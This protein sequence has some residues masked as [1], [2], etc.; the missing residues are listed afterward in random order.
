MKRMVSFLTAVVVALALVAVPFTGLAEDV[1]F[2]WF[3]DVS[4]WGPANWN[5]VNSSPLLDT[6]KSELGA[7]FE[8][9]QPATDAATKLALMIATNDLPDL[10][11]ITDS[12]TIA[13]LIESGYV[14]TIPEFVEKYDP[15]SHLLVDFPED[16]K[17][18]IVD[19]YGD[20]WF[21]PSHME[22]VQH[23]ETYPL[24]SQAYINNVVYGQNSSIMFNQKIMDDLGLTQEDV[25]TQSAFMATLQKVKDSGYTVNG[26][27]VIVATMNA[28][29]WLSSLN[30]VMSDSFG[31]V[32]VDAEGNYRRIEMNPGF[33]EVLKFTNDM[34]RGGYM[35]LDILTLDENALV[36][37]IEA[38]QVFC[39]FGN[40]AQADLSVSNMTSFGPI[41]S[42]TGAVP[43]VGINS[44][45]GTGWIKTFVSKSCKNPEVLA[46]ALSFAT[47]EEGLWLN[48]Y[49]VRDV[50]Y[51]VQED[52]T[53]V[54]TEE[55]LK[56]YNENYAANI[57][58]WP[59]NDTDFFW[60]TTP[61]PDK[62]AD[63]ANGSDMAYSIACSALGRYE[64]TYIYNSGLLTT[65]NSEPLEAS[66]DLGI[67]YAQIKNYLQSQK[68]KIIS[69]TTDEEF[70]KEYQNMIDTLN[71]YDVTAVDAA[72]N[73]YL[74]AAY[75][76]NDQ[77]I[78]NPNAAIY[79]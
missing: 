44:Q 34:V 30:G 33:K 13:Q 35:D 20:F 6:L 21:F 8:I 24:C 9:E 12:T 78:E 72:L 63:G 67:K 14:Y 64:T 26:N 65:V 56:R 15:E 59:F 46:K 37:Y 79:E 10:M 76:A 54:R 3:S 57:W 27:P 43:T 50:D 58:L 16:V 66:S 25:Q 51:T 38:G 47:S 70:E 29:L 77:K 7:S 73:E 62:Q 49:G 31:L 48:Y 40:P 32:P 71:S 17:K 5:G 36:T 4:G 1:T 11:S 68:A 60:C 42:D 2:S 75:A 53:M 39:W 19:A 55:G 61:G 52:G 28:N 41:L 45:A 69:A 23:R 22:S 74:Q 18:A